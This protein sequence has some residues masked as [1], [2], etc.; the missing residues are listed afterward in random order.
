[1]IELIS[2]YE[3][4]VNAIVDE[5]KKKQEIKS[6]EGYWI[7]KEIGGVYD[8][9]DTMTFDFRDILTDIKTNAEKDEIFKWQEYNLRI[10]SLNNMVGGMFLQEINYSNWLKGCP[11]LSSDELDK[12]EAKYKKLVE[13][14]AAL[15][16]TTTENNVKSC[17]K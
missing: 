8:F 9:G 3:N 10:W 7:G 1:M 16:K 6:S 2:N 14:I 5:F 15:G 4:A 17:M 11:R 12:V 13:E